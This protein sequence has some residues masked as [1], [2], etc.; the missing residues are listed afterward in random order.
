MSIFQQ[1]EWRPARSVDR[2]SDALP[3]DPGVYLLLIKRGDALLNAVGYPDYGLGVPWAVDGWV[4]LYT[5]RSRTLRARVLRHLTANINIS[6]VRETLV[7]LHEHAD[8]LT[9]TG[10]SVEDSPNLEV[11]LTRWL[12]RQCRVGFMKTP[13]AEELE[14]HILRSTTS[15]LNIA[16]RK[17]QGFTGHLEAIRRRAAMKRVPPGMLAFR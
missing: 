8:A 7:A 15:P 13:D 10:V 11:G 2:L 5:G 3:N 1:F 6:N 14:R 9:A 16:G 4:H 12:A 17:R